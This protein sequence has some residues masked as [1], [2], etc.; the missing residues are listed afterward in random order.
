MSTCEKG[1]CPETATHQVR[2]WSPGPIP[3]DATCQFCHGHA[4]DA[5]A[6]AK[7]V[8][9]VT[10]VRAIGHAVPVAYAEPESCAVVVAA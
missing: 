6:T 4:L 7:R 3:T 5:R 8:F 9:V 10:T 1:G 2:I